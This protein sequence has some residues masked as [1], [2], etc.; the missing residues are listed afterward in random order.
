MSPKNL[1]T[2]VTE[3][4]VDEIFSNAVV[5]PIDPPLKKASEPTVD[6]DEK[7]LQEVAHSAGPRIRS[8]ADIPAHLIPKGPHES[9]YQGQGPT[10][11]NRV[12]I[13]SAGGN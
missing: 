5:T 2:K 8:G 3:K 10:K 1:P 13:R 9:L 4:V 6:V 11:G 12:T 7:K